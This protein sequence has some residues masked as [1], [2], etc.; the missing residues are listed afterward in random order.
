MA[1]LRSILVAVLVLVLV[2]VPY[3]SVLTSFSTTQLFCE[4]YIPQEIK[5]RW[6]A[7][8]YNM[9][10]ALKTIE[11]RAPQ[12]IEDD[13]ELYYATRYIDRNGHLFYRTDEDRA[14][15]W[16]KAE[17]SWELLMGYE[18]PR[19]DLFFIPYPDFRDF[20]MA[21]VIIDTKDNY[22]GKGIAADPNY[23]FVAMGGPCKVNRRT[24][25]LYMDYQDFYIS[26]RAMPEW[27]L[28]FFMRGYARNWYAIERNRP[29]LAFTIIGVTDKVM[30]VRGS[31]TGGMAVFRRI[32]EDMREVSYG[33]EGWLE[34]IKGLWDW[35]GRRGTRTT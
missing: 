18:D 22:F 1:T 27:D 12:R 29:P 20:A 9:E 25:Q 31:K 5:Q 33:A 23:S 10:K 4:A 2:T 3:P 19:N 17:G 7:P 30:I 16:R 6:S 35:K 21:Y 28:S 32:K 14:E 26:G 13:Y 15:L 34:G 11:E 24:R 8:D